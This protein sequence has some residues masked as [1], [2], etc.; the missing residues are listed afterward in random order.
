MAAAPESAPADAE[1]IAMP[2]DVWAR[3]AAAVQMDAA[4]SADAQALP[5]ESELLKPDPMLAPKKRKAR[6]QEESFD[7]ASPRRL[8]VMLAVVLL[9]GVA[10]TLYIV[11]RGAK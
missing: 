7:V 2:A 8:L 11:M 9:A 1:P 3:V 6:D 5:A 4:A 10:V